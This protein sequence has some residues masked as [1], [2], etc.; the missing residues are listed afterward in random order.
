MNPSG[1]LNSLPITGNA[2]VTIVEEK[3]DMKV[4]SDTSIVVIHFRLLL[5]FRG[6]LGSFG[7]SQVI[8]KGCKCVYVNQ[9][10]HD[11]QLSLC[12]LYWFLPC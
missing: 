8:Y 2:G 5:Q 10:I 1:M 3:G 4:K 12:F 7:P 11:L 6:L 9:K